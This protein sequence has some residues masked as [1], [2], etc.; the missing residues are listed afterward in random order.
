M[1]LHL[2]VPTTRQAHN[3]ERHSIHK[4][5]SISIEQSWNTIKSLTK[6]HPLSLRILPNLILSI[7]QWFQ[8][9]LVAQTSEKDFPT[10]NPVVLQSL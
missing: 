4:E 5:I 1:E 9:A 3:I 8:L 6:R 10:S 7:L 2:L